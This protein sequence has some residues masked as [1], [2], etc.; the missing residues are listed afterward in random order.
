[1]GDTIKA[2][3]TK[4]YAVRKGKNP[5]VYTDVEEYRAQVDGF[6]GY[7]ARVFKNEKEAYDF[8]AG[9]ITETEIRED[10]GRKMRG[11][12]CVLS[13]KNQSDWDLKWRAAQT[14]AAYV[15]GSHD[16][17]LNKCGYGVMIT[18]GDGREIM[19][20]GTSK[21][22]SKTGLRSVASEICAIK[23]AIQWAQRKKVKKLIIVYDCSAPVELINNNTLIKN[24]F[25]KEFVQFYKNIISTCKMEIVFRKIDG[26][27]GNKYHE[28]AD[29]LAR[30][31]LGKE[32]K[33]SQR[34]AINKLGP[35]NWES[36]KPK[37]KVKQPKKELRKED[38]NRLTTHSS[39]YRIDTNEKGII[40][41]NV[42][43]I[44][45]DG[46]R[47]TKLIASF[48]GNFVNVERDEFGKTVFMHR[49]NA[50]QKR[51]EINNQA[52]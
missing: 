8:V 31:S 1:M 11:I 50:E 3:A 4:Y 25:A 37:E 28:M 46:A 16:D 9:K 47:I 23:A 43:S 10:R 26:H 27:V 35:I 12:A 33:S 22:A 29:A 34:Q 6:T 45:R 14:V 5:G 24:E 36:E 51:I 30:Y 49:E 18:T 44:C 39:I 40:R 15:D 41:G 13:E 17:N 52:S 20:Y 42:L 48:N 2:K 32:I 38:Y 7:S 21:E 19:L